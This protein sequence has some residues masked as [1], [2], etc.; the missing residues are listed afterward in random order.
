[1]DKKPVISPFNWRGPAQSLNRFGRM[2][3]D[4]QILL[5]ATRE[6]KESTYHTPILKT[7]S[8]RAPR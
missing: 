1:M 4:R 3:T 2:K 7:N 5:D 6:N 8:Y